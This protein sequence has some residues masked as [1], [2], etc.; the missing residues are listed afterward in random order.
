[1]IIFRTSYVLN[2]QKSKNLVYLN[3][4]INLTKHILNQSKNKREF[5]VLTKFNHPNNL[6]QN[7]LLLKFSKVFKNL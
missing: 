2:Y 1:M 3:S 7:H 4:S 5:N 6:L